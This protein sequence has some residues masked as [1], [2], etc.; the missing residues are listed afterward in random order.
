MGNYLCVRRVFSNVMSA[1]RPRLGV[2]HP[3]VVPTN[4]EPTERTDRPETERDAGSAE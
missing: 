1:K 2:D 3:T 4:F